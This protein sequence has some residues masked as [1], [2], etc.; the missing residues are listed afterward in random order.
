MSPAD[1]QGPRDRSLPVGAPTVTVPDDVLARARA[2]AG[3]PRRLLGV[4]GPPGAGKSTFAAAL[5]AALG[6]RAVTV[7]MDGFHLPGA[8]LERCGLADRK[9]APETFD[10]EGLL[11]LLGRLREPRGATVRAPAF[12][13]EAE[14]PVPDAVVVEPDVP[15]VVLEGNY[16]LHDDGAWARVRP[17]L[18]ECWYVAADDDTRVE[19]LVARHVAFGR[20]PAA[21]RA[22]VLRS[23]EANARL[24]ARGR[25]RADLVVRA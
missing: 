25:A 8:E 17:L 7:P 16:L 13:R 20:T 6:G 23:D 12:D 1:A 19:R 11:A 4:A 21:A 10:A 2:L 24:V 5:V 14:E 9:G 3:G 15:L 18:D 22:W